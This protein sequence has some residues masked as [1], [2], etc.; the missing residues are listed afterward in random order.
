MEEQRA[1]PRRKVL[2]GGII[3]FPNGGGLSCRVRN[4]SDTGACLE[5][6]SP[7]GIP[8]KFFL[9]IDGDKRGRQA[10]VVWREGRKLGVAYAE[11]EGAPDAT[12]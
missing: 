2:K 6:E 12:G 1:K 11:A 3:E 9:L 4:V 7:Q 8:N 10:R 5:I